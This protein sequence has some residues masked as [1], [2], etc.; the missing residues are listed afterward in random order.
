MRRISLTILI[1][2]VGV[3]L[4]PAIAAGQTRKASAGGFPGMPELVT[5]F[6]AA[7]LDRSLYVYGGH[8]G[9]AHAYWNTSQARTLWKLDLKQPGEWKSLGEGPRLQ[10]LALVAHEGKLY[11]IGG[12]QAKNK[13]GDAQDLWSQADVDCYDVATGKW[14]DAPPLPEPR[15]SFDA[16]VLNGRIYVVGG[17]TL[18]GEAESKWLQT[19]YAL[20]TSESSPR[21]S[22][23]P[24]PPFQR[25]ALAVAAHAGKIFAIGGMQQQGGPTTRVDVFDPETQQWTQGP[26][27][28]GE[29]M[30]GFGA[31]AFA[32]GGRLYV[33]T[34]HGQLQRL[35][36]DGKS[37]SIVQKLA[38]ARFFH[39]MLPI[40]PTQLIV[41][42]GASMQSGKF[43]DLEVVDVRNE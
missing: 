30:D 10:G 14:G 19:A 33:S 22:R 16:A 24:K 40:S 28:N 4:A 8:T 12:F 27:L 17:W 25:R 37:W 3:G 34:Y 38:N 29:A 6:G 1:L 20:D 7:V 18:A 36:N 15:S 43:G 5:S 2:G 9:D 13:E 31:S 11:R 42:G 23:L 39:R 26:S 41:V 21:W 32:A 35:S